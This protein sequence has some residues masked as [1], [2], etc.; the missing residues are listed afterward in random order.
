MIYKIKL[1]VKIKKINKIYQLKKQIVY[2]YYLKI[3]K[4]FMFVWEFKLSL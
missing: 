1:I 4:F 3:M 2:Y